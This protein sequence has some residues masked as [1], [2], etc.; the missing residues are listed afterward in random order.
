MAYDAC[1]EYAQGLGVPWLVLS[2]GY[3]TG[4]THLV[5]A[6]AA[7]LVKTNSSVRVWYV[8]TL[9]DFLKAGLNAKE[10]DISLMDAVSGVKILILDDLG[11]EYSTDYTE[12][13]LEKLLKIRYEGEKHTVVTTN[14][15]LTQLPGY[16]QSLVSDNTVCRWLDMQGGK[17]FRR[18]NNG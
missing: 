7:Q 5:R 3:G 13:L 17:D 1:L 4:K 14:L 2:G 18:S 11:V 16:L 9:L 15:T 10:N 8:P 12:S 6:I